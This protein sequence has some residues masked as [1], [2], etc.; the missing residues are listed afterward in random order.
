MVAKEWSAC[1]FSFI[2]AGMS[3]PSLPIVAAA[4]FLAS[5]A[6][7]RALIP[8]LQQ[9][10]VLDR[11]NDRSSHVAPT[12]RGGGLAILVVALPICGWYADG[13]ELVVYAAALALA[14][15]SWVDDIRGLSVVVRLAVQMM[16]VAGV[17]LLVPT[18]LAL[19][20]VVVVAIAWIWFINL[21]N[22]MDGID[23]ITGIETITLGLGASAVLALSGAPVSMAL[24]PVVLVAA[25]AG[26]LVWNWQP[27]KIF[28]G[29]V[30]SVP[31]GFLVGWVLLELVRID[32][33]AAALILAAYYLADATITLA[34]RGLRGEK[35]WRA[36]KEHFYQRAHQGGLSHAAVSLRI[37]AANLCLVGLAAVAAVGHIAIGLA[38]ATV[39][40][41]FLLFNLA[42]WG[43]NA[44]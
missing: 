44:A 37:L 19:P 6:V 13:A 2:S 12:P 38:G 36:H 5:L 31:L 18:D 27:A 40:V 26:F 29:D 20:I 7:T 24:L 25:S 39:V 14:A 34:R 11:P 10:H 41:G 42:Q 3:V 22:F 21:Y 43:K 23:G 4:V 32:Q 30:G 15:V 9:R 8:W 28:M 16:A 33:A 35:I 17:L 1:I